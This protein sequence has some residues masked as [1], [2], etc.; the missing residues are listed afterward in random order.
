MPNQYTPR[1]PVSERFWAKVDKSGDCWLW[2]ANK[3]LGYGRFWLHDTITVMAHRWAYEET[4][5][6]IPD[7]LEIDHLC[8]NR[9][10]VR[11][12]HL[13]AVTCVENIHRSLPYRKQWD[14]CSRGHP[15]SPENTLVV[16]NKNRCRICAREAGTNFRAAHPGYWKIYDA[17]RPSRRRISR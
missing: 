6:P 11:P 14:S 4:H 3:N 7:E 17:V 10:C 1:I 16:R 5:G 13:E 12:T 2:T 15:Y 9:A 8:R